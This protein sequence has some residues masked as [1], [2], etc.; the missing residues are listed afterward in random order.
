M[1]PPAVV[2]RPWPVGSGLLPCRCCRLS[3]LAP[4]PKL[5]T[6]EIHF[7]VARIR[8]LKPY[9]Q[10][11]TSTLLERPGTVVTVPTV[12]RYSTPEYTL[13]LLLTLQVCRRWSSLGSAKNG[14][15]WANNLLAP[16][17]CHKYFQVAPPFI[18][19]MSCLAL[20]LLILDTT[21]TT[22]VRHDRIRI[23]YAT[24]YHS[25]QCR[26]VACSTRA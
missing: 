18:L 20:E 15:Q 19:W 24:T 21:Y 3:S 26:T 9:P 1:L 13:P 17:A 14:T 25:S 11:S 5:Q 12:G 8:T 23:S 10:A 7:R 22:S 2:M 4:R 6:L 16:T